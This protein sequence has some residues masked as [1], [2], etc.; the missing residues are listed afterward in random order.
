M[1]NPVYPTHVT[2]S[3]GLRM[4]TGAWQRPQ[5]VL[6]AQLHFYTADFVVQD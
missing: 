5:T 4:P 1:A 6:R 2:L 3:S